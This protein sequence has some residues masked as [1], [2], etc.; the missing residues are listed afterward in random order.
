VFPVQTTDGKALMGIWICDFTQAS[1]GAHHELQISFFVS[2]EEV[3]PIVPHP[4]NTLIAIVTRKDVQMMCFGL[5]NST[6]EVV[7]FNREILSLN[8]RLSASRISR[9]SN[10]LDFAIEDAATKSPIISGSVKNPF[11]ASPS[12]TFSFM[13]R[14]GLRQNLALARQPWINMQVLNPT[15][16]VLD[17]NAAAQ[18]YTKNDTTALQFFDDASQLTISAPAY[19]PLNFLPQ[20]IQYMDGFKFVYMQPEIV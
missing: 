10:S 2:R 13:G 17:V 11:K 12:A 8:A 3:A 14:L 1:L 7:A 4:L 16:V 6:P 19:Q 20:V 9:S 18:T 5:W 15:G